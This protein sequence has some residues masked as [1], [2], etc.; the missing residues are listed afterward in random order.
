MLAGRG[1]ALL[2]TDGFITTVNSPPLKYVA[3][4]Y[5]LWLPF[6]FVIA[7]TAVAVIALFERRT[8]LGV[9]TEAVGINPEASRLA[10]VRSRG[11]IFGAYVV[12]GTLAGIAGIIYSSN[13]MAADA[14]AAG[15][16][17]ELY[18]ILA[19]VLGGTSL[20]GG[21]F[22]IAGHRHR[23]PH[24][25]DAQVDDPLPRGLLG[26][27]PG[28]LRGR[29]DPRGADP[30][31]SCAPH[32]ARS[33]RRRAVPAGP[34]PARRGGPSMSTSVATPSRSVVVGRYVRTFL[35]R[36]ASLMPTFA[37]LVIFIVLLVGAQIHFGNFVTPLNMS[38]LLLDNAYLLIL[39]V[40][41]TFVIVTGGIDLSVGSV[42]A[43]TGI[44]CA[45][46]LGAGH[47]A[48]VVVPGDRSSAA[49]RSACSSACSCSTSTSSRS[50]RRWRGSSS[51]EAWRS[52]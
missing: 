2:I 6:A 45:H 11:I 8:A 5:L 46:L 30:V 39:A 3:S 18:A 16:L 29:R 15:D 49:P 26:A 12:S 22:T 17:I 48:A 47:S 42:M 23:R 31:T 10:G 43:F 40:G 32:G 44:L 20:M 38:A 41:M 7:I 13:I 25:P 9:L 50:S 51:P 33:H 34:D 19:V 21:K 1:V 52:S 27:E 36:H 37:A 24:H 35:D 4:G 14:N 28:V